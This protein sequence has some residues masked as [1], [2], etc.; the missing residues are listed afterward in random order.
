MAPITSG[1]TITAA[2][3]SPRVSS[4]WSSAASVEAPFTEG[5]GSRS[6]VKRWSRNGAV[7]RSAALTL[8]APKVSPW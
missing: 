4:R 1:S 6:T 5:S 8:M 3:S 2:T 7:K